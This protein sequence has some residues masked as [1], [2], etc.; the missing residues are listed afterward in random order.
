MIIAADP[1]VAEKVT[2]M[3]ATAA[4]PLSPRTMAR[5][6]G[7]EE[8]LVWTAARAL[9]REGMAE[10]AGRGFSFLAT[11]RARN[12]V[13]AAISMEMQDG[14]EESADALVASFAALTD[15][16]IADHDSLIQAEHRRYDEQVRAGRAGIVAGLQA[17]VASAAPSGWRSSAQFAMEDYRRKPTRARAEAVLRYSRRAVAASDPAR[18]RSF[19]A[20]HGITAAYDPVMLSITVRGLTAATVAARRTQTGAQNPTPPRQKAPTVATCCGTPMIPGSTRPCR[21]GWSR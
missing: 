10:E 21:C 1:F 14:I 13:V 9:V 2:A 3:L 11:D 12:A 17:L 20:A 19:D 4:A 16:E 6:L 7:E 8:T 5:T 18:L 15:E